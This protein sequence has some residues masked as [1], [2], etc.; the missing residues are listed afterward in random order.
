MAFVIGWLVFALAVAVVAGQRGRSGTAW[1]MIAVVLSPLFA[2][3]LLLA[4][5]VGVPS[6]VAA[7]VDDGRVLTEDERRIEARSRR[8]SH[9]TLAVLAALLIAFFIVNYFRG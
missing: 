8:P 2:V 9:F 6:P 1:F 5:P 7:A 4:S 3:L